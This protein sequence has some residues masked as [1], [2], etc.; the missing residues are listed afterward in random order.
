MICILYMSI[1]TF[2]YPHVYT[3]KS[4]KNTNMWFY[5]HDRSYI[6]GFPNRQH[7]KYVQKYV[8]TLTKCDFEVK[9][10]VDT[11]ISLIDLEITKRICIND[12]PSSLI[13][14]PI[15]EYIGY[16]L[17][18]NISIIFAVDVVEEKD[19]FLAESILIES[20]KSTEIFRKYA[21]WE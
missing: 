4:Y 2:N 13:E 15:E 6:I 1:M 10:K 9:E 21:K 18:N 8:S 20:P 7:A 3:I 5:K 16:T 11:N 14:V 19:K 17:N 12:L